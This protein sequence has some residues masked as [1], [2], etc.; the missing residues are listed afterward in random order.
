MVV[1]ASNRLT[2]TCR[3]GSFGSIP[4][5]ILARLRH[6]QDL[7]EARPDRFL[8][9]EYPALLDESRAALAELVRA[10]PD[11]IVL[12]SNATEGVNTVLKGLA[13][14]DGGGDVILTFSKIGRAHV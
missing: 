7:A 14:A 1:M 5:V 8:R 12:V 4:K 9:Y 2:R 6:Y 3:P 13:W 10:P 11:T